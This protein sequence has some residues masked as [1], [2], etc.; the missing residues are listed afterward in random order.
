MPHSIFTIAS[1]FVRGLGCVYEFSMFF[2]PYVKALT[3]IRKCVSRAC[4][5]DKFLGCG[6]LTES[7]SFGHK[8]K[9]HNKEVIQVRD[10]KNKIRDLCLIQQD[11]L[12]TRL[13]GNMAINTK[14]CVYIKTAHFQQKQGNLS[15]QSTSR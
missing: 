9:Q 2:L 12:Q 10:F 6:V 5:F 14:T 13:H 8:I 11:L 7:V 15:P 3:I 4:P 1:G